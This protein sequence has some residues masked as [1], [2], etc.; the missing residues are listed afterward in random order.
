MKTGERFNWILIEN[1]RWK[2]INQIKSIFN[3]KTRTMIQQRRNTIAYA[4]TKLTQQERV[5]TDL[6][7]ENYELNKDVGT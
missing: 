4:K 3:F 2:N 1:T 7:H 5:E 6:K